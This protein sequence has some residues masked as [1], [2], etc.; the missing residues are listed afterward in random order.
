MA[1]ADRIVAGVNMTES[2]PLIASVGNTVDETTRRPQHRKSTSVASFA[3]LPIPQ[4]RK[5]ST[6]VWIVC[7]IIFVVAGSGGFMVIPLTR[8][9]EDIFCRQYYG[10][11]QILGEPIDESQCKADEIQSKLAYLFAIN[12]SLTAGVG[13][14]AAMPWGI[15]ADK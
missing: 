15:A 6:V 9:F 5:P 2:T 4:A 10:V 3:S 7:V 11:P 14:L 1:E 12:N 8:V 13:C